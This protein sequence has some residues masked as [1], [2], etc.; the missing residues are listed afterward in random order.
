MANKDDVAQIFVE[1]QTGDIGDMR[2]ESDLRGETPQQVLLVV[3]VAIKLCR[4]MAA[5]AHNAVERVL[6]GGGAGF[7]CGA[8]DIALRCRH[9]LVAEQLHQGVHADVGVGQL[10]G[11]GVSSGNG[12]PIP[13]S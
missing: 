11:V 9:R 7:A 5:I 4:L 12:L 3:A 1:Q 8:G 13:A 2:I 6:S 10:S